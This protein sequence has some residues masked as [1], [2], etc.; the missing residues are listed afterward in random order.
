MDNDFYGNVFSLQHKNKNTQLS[1]GGALTKYE[2]NHFG[3]LVW[4]SKG[5]TNMGKWYNLNAVK[6]DFNIYTKLQQQLVLHF[7]GF[8]D[9]QYRHIKYAINGFRDNPG[10]IINNNYNFFNPKIG[11]S[12]TNN[13]WLGYVSYSQG[14]KEP[15]RDDFEAGIDQQPKPERLHDFELGIEKRNTDYSWG[16]TAYYMKYKDQLVL[17][18]QINDVGAYTRTNIPRS[19]RAGIELQGSTKITNW[20]NAE[21]NIAFSR[22]KV[23]HFTEYIDDYDGGG[24]K[25]FSYTSADIAYSPSI[26]GGATI[27]FVAVENFE[28]SFLSK[29][30]AKQYLDNTQNE[31]RKLNA[32]YVQ[33]ARAIYTIKKEWLKEVNIFIQANNIFNKKYEPNGYTFSYIYGGELTTQNYFFPMAGTNFMMGVNVRL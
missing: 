31:N 11:I 27:S 2:G 5:F 14:N 17:T 25:T 28:F 13:G 6:T 12:Y 21:G 19:Y 26:V 33:D 24:Q 1:F 18:G 9:L 32:F 4:A 7:N 22:N 20:L 10:L 16:A 15:N 3:K 29:Y 8:I 30:A 23:Q